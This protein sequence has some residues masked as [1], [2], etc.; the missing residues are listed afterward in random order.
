M[1]I[2]FAEFI[3][4]AG[5]RQL[6]RN[7]HEV[8][9]VPKAF[10]L[11]ELLLE[12]RPDAV[13]REE[14]RDRLWPS[15][16]VSES[17]LTSLV[18]DLRA[19]LDDDAAEPRFV[20]TV[21]GRGYAFAGAAAP[22]TA[23]QTQSRTRQ[24]PRLV[25]WLGAALLVAAAL[26]GAWALGLRTAKLESPSFTR[27]TFRRGIVQ[28]ARF[29]PDGQTILYGAGWEGEPSRIYIGRADSLDSR[30]LDLPEGDILSISRNGEMAVVL[31]RFVSG[32]PPGMLARVSLAGGAPRELA[33]DVTQ[34]DWSPD[35]QKLAIVRRVARADQLEFPIG[36]VVHS[37]GTLLFPAVSPEGERVAFLS[38]GPEGGVVS[39]VDRDG[40]VKPLARSASPFGLAWGPRGDEVWYSESGGPFTPHQGTIHAVDMRGRRRV[41]ARLPG[42]VTLNDVSREGRVLLTVAQWH[43]SLTAQLPGESSEK[44]MSWFDGAA[45]AALS[46]DGRTLLFS[47][48][49]GVYV[50][51]TDGA[52][53]VR[54]GAGRALD[55]S[56]DG[57]W[58]LASLDKAEATLVLL[59]TGA[60]ETRSVSLE[61]LQPIGYGG[62]FFPD[63]RRIYVNARE[64][65]RG[66]RVYVQGLAGEGRR[67]VTPAGYA[68]TS[69]AVSPDGREI[70]VSDAQGRLFLA[71]VKGGE[72]RPIATDEPEASAYKDASSPMQWS[73][74]GRYIY[75]ANAGKDLP[76]G[77]ERLTPLRIDR[78]DLR[79]GRRDPWRS[80]PIADPAGV[81]GAVSFHMTP[82]QRAYAYSYGRILCALY[83]V[84]GLS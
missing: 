83:L 38:Y 82:D 53:A 39:V 31:G 11:L 50:R 28:S 59:P 74:D 76:M 60:G 40:T 25:P 71:P 6:L 65:E 48:R 24:R 12:R 42:P 79:T 75:V 63:S 43:F 1:R 44:D 29:A 33:R 34:A 55:L 3:L 14:I 68:A 30:P 78:V 51:R 26:A 77:V 7:G 69:N 36:R 41:L 32:R 18:T 73:A 49:G 67:A 22:A 4:D 27:L 66:V 5:S 13:S 17:T 35:G 45:L 56:P 46:P 16:F 72:P 23:A 57:Q 15:T 70:L 47:D 9:V 54:L 20:R 37:G 21:Y 2:Q 52:P 62:G 58:A 80:I 8:R 64:G 81:T 61:G 10:D 84:E 19:A